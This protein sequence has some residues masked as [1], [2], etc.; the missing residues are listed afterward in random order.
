MQSLL[1]SHWARQYWMGKTTATY[2]FTHESDRSRILPVLPPQRPRE[3]TVSRLTHFSIQGQRHAR[4]VTLQD[5]CVAKTPPSC[6]IRQYKPPDHCPGPSHRHQA[7]HGSPEK[8]STMY[9]PCHTL[10]TIQSRTV[11][12]PDKPN[13]VCPL[14]LVDPGREPPPLSNPS[15]EER[16]RRVS[17]FVRQRVTGSIESWTSSKSLRIMV[18][19]HSFP[20]LAIRAS[21]VLVV[22]VVVPC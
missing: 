14:G 12:Y 11:A 9:L 19:S 17:L 6:V 7:T 4:L 2:R 13:R 18:L 3:Q 10:L 21:G 22:V 16:E 1:S 8:S 15:L 5:R 20:P